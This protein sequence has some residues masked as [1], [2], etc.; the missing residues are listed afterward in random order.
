VPDPASTQQVSYPVPW[1]LVFGLTSHIRRGTQRDLLDFTSQ[2]VARMNPPPHVEGLENLPDSSKFVLTANHYQRKGLWI[3]HTAAALSQAIA[4]RY[5]AVGNPPVRWMVTANWP[6]IRLGAWTIASPGD[7]LLPRVAHALH[8]YPVTFAGNNPSFTAR[9]IRR[10]L[11]DASTLHSPLGIF[12]E[13]VAG[14][15]HDLGP[16]LPGVDRLLQQLAKRGLPVVPALVSENAGRL[17]LRFGTPITAAE[18]L[19]APNAAL[20]A[21]NQIRGLRHGALA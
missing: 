11:T 4:K 21:M 14:S 5:P 7:W 20:L 15:A 12:P 17:T 3:L 13:G 9:T 6:P 2:I 1:D 16:P 8:C 19:T 18:V 10:I